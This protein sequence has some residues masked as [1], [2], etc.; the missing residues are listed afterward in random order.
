M[1]GLA[2]LY[3]ELSGGRFEY[4]VV[5]LKKVILSHELG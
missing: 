1:V 5:E 4:S 3:C 2:V